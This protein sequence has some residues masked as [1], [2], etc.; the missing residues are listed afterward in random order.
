MCVLFFFFFQAED[1]IR[2][3]A[4]TGVQ[5]CAL[6]IY[7]YSILNFVRS[8]PLQSWRLG[9]SGEC[10]LEPLA[11]PHRLDLHIGPL[12]TCQLLQSRRAERRDPVA[13]AALPMQ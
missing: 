4:V 7:Q 10:L 8:T 13:V 12:G 11:K 6:P 3:V 9:A 1:G 2:D 5:T